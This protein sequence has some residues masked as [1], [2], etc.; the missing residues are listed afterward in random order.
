MSTPITGIIGAGMM[1]EAILAGLLASGRP[2]DSVVVGEKLP[3]RAAELREKY[4]VDV[5]STLEVAERADTLLVLVK[6]YDVDA[7][8]QEVSGSLRAGQLVVSLAAGVPIAFLEERVPEGVA[9]ARVMPNT[10]AMVGE[11]M[12]AVSPGSACTEEQTAEVVD[13]LSGVGRA[14]VVPEKQQDAVTAVSG[15]GPAYVF[16]VAEAMI[17][18]GVHLGLARPTATELAAQTLVGAAT[19][20][21]DSGTHPSILRE[22]VTSPG[23][24]T[25]AALRKL[26]D[27]AVRAAFLDAM[28]ACRDRSVELG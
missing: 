1:G 6:P 7:A 2:K 21:R 22:Q 24:T 4:A 17:E 13:L 26:D 15:S 14:I 18:A 28:E 11:G 23:G 25:A 20:L 16:Y 19:M 12:A 9:V 5:V 10:P 3:A 8:L 27:H